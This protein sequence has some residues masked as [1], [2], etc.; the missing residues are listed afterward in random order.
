MSETLDVVDLH[1]H[2]LPQMDDGSDSVQ[3]S[4]GLLTMQAKQGVTIVCFTPHYYAEQNS[5]ERFAQ[6]RAEALAKLQG[7]IPPEIREIRYGAEVAFFSGISNCDEL[8]TLCLNDTNTLMLEMPFTDWSHGVVE[9][10]AR[11]VLDRHYHVVIVHPERFCYSDSNVRAIHELARL[12][13]C[14]QVNANTLMHWR[15]RKQ[16]LELLQ[17]THTPLLGTDCHNLG[18]RKP[19]MDKARAVVKRKLGSDFLQA[20]DENALA[21]IR[22]VR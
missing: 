20:I 11:L 17:L 1:C 2:V 5:I 4:V 22:P 9:E 13:L 15:T 18:E 21:A 8:D 14:L 6:R 19:N 12:P 10:V 3:T 7:N 16:G